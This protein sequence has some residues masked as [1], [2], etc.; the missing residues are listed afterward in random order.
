MHYD[1]SKKLE[2]SQALPKTF[3]GGLEKSLPSI[4]K[5]TV[6]VSG[7]TIQGH[8]QQD[9][10]YLG[11]D[12][13]KQASEVGTEKKILV[14]AKND[15]EIVTLANTF[16][17]DPEKQ[18]ESNDI[19]T[20]IDPEKHS[21]ANE[22]ITNTV[23]EYSSVLNTSSEISNNNSGHIILRPNLKISEISEI[24]VTKKVKDKKN[25]SGNFSPAEGMNV[26]SA[27]EATENVQAVNNNMN[28]EKIKVIEIVEDIDK[29]DFNGDINLDSIPSDQPVGSDPEVQRQIGK[30][31]E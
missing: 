6:P 2:G 16:K 23:M 21:E 5:T 27:G 10:V 24:K 25:E 17:I 1:I 8:V 28:N 22:G 29:T 14:I 7:D 15:K 4:Q 3:S 31:F 30:F 11:L 20:E 26:N 18:N 13:K 19:I 12:Y 9:S